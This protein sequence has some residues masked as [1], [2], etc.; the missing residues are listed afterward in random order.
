MLLESEP[1]PWAQDGDRT[2]AHGVTKSEHGQRSTTI[3]AA[4][5][6]DPV[7]RLIDRQLQG[8]SPSHED[9]TLD[10]Q[11]LAL[12]ARCGLGSL[13]LLEATPQPRPP[14]LRVV[15]QSPGEAQQRCELC[16]QVKLIL[17]PAR[18]PSHMFT[19]SGELP[20]QLSMLS[21][22]PAWV[23]GIGRRRMVVQR[24][25]SRRSL[26]VDRGPQAGDFAV[27]VGFSD[28]RQ[29][30][31]VP[32]HS[33]RVKGPARVC[34]YGIP[35]ARL[36]DSAQTVVEPAGGLAAAGSVA[37]ASVRVLEVADPQPISIPV[38]LGA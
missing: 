1:S 5:A 34:A 38:P 25:V 4:L 31:I 11:P 21:R 9:L 35:K 23:T 13:E 18:R 16:A 22:S 30:A 19:Q 17:A 2:D 26:A 3:A 8:I 24:S 29:S 12:S 32:P 36:K 28:D 10:G 33:T 15:P 7:G 20:T 37:P 27:N 14:G 6:C